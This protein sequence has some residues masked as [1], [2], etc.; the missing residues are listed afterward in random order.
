MQLISVKIMSGKQHSWDSNSYLYSMTFF[1][2]KELSVILSIKYFWFGEIRY[3]V[4][5]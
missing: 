3:S 5:V 1:H 2:I 4:T